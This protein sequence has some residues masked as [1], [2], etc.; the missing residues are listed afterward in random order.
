MKTL[1][2]DIWD[3]HAFGYPIVIPV[4]IGY[5][6]DGTAVMGR[7]VALQASDRYPEVKERWGN[8][9]Q[10]LDGNVT[11]MYDE[12]MNFIYFPTKPLNRAEPHMSWKGKATM[13]TVKKSL[14]AL[15]HVVKQHDILECMMPLVGCGNGGLSKRLV[16]KLMEQNL[17]DKF[18]LVELE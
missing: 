13:D 3:L 15:L 12:E 9:C 8:V 4:N 11:T 16:K 6:G 5:K 10:A 18:T 2:G 14:G 1:K 7:G 17:D